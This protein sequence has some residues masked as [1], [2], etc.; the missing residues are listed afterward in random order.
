LTFVEKVSK[1]TEKLG[2]RTRARRKRSVLLLLAAGESI[3]LVH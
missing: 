2:K 3:N 1:Y